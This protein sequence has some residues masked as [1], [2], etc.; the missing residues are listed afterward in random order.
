MKP[1]LTSIALV[2]TLP[3]LISCT[4]S[5]QDSSRRP[6]T[7][8]GSNGQ[9]A[10]TANGTGA[11]P[12][13]PG[14][15]GNGTGN[16]SGGAGT[17][18]G[19]GSSANAS[20][21]NGTAS[22]AL[23]QVPG[24]RRLS[25]NEY[26][27]TVLDMLQT[28]L[29]TRAG[30]AIT[31]GIADGFTQ[32]SSVD[33]FDNSRTALGVTPSLAGQYADAAEKLAAEA[34][35]AGK[36]TAL[37]PCAGGA[38]DVCASDF[39]RTFGQQL[40]RRPVA[41][42][43]LTRYATLF[44]TERTRSD[45][46]T[47]IRQ[48][49]ETMLQTPAFLYRSEYGTPALAGT[50]VLTDYETASL[51]SYMLWSSPPDAELTAAAAAGTLATTAGRET[52]ARRLLQSPRA[53]LPLQY[54]VTEWTGTS[55][56]ASVIKDA[57][58]YPMF[59][60]TMRQ[61]LLDGQEAFIKKTT[62]DG[63]GSIATLL[64][65]DAGMLTQPWLLTV[66]AHPDES[67]PIA[68]GKLVRTRLLCQ[69]L[70]VPPKNL[71]V[72]PVAKDPNATTRQRFTAHS[73][74]PACAGCHV[75]IDPIGFGFERYDGIGQYRAME[76]GLPVDDS[77]ELTATEDANGPFHGPGELGTKLAASAEVQRCVG[78][79]AFRY[80]Y[81]Y[82]A[83]AA[84]IAELSPVLA[85]LKTANNNIRELFVLFAKSQQFVTRTATP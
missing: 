60:A 18:T 16:G 81:G 41:A 10:S 82:S 46:A 14:S 75:L 42:D 23:A 24:I 8:P 39:V 57:A 51:L 52:A 72:V 33:G 4:G 30:D 11:S 19:T 9:G 67:F 65:G 1:L 26:N 28:A 15:G 68:R 43:E 12:G 58:T 73:N 7:G 47:S 40:F 35:T 27:H 21:G 54:F 76:N 6:G 55:R 63:D 61:S 74:N 25:H 71:M 49:L 85:D 66:H 22:G 50:R 56:L 78:R 53:R 36:L 84:E 17:G 48:L 44:A 31:K 5:A 77:G 13:T 32:D 20:G 69:E 29:V 2:A 83:G 3:L 79:Q 34:L 45:Y 62:W 37:A 80:V 70:P 38:E 59:D 64:T